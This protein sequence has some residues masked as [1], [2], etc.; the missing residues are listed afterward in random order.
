MQR[1]LGLP[2]DLEAFR[3]WTLRALKKHGL[4]LA[5]TAFLA[6]VAVR[7][8][9]RETGG[10]PAVPLDDSFIHF[11]Y[12]RS[13]WEGRFLGYTPG[14]A[15]A[16]GA[17]SLLWP[18]L[19]ALPYALGL[20]GELLIWAAWL[21]GFAALGLLGYETRRASERLLS[22]DG[23]IAAEL[24]VLTFGGNLWF[25]ASGME[26]IPLA[27]LLLRAARRSAEWA[28]NAAD[29]PGEREL[30]AIAWLGPLLR[31]EGT[32][33][34]LLVTAALLAFPRKRR[35][36]GF[37]ALAGAALPGLLNLWG[38][39]TATTNTAV[40]KWLPLSPYLDRDELWFAF[41][42]NVKLLF[43]TLLNGEVWS[44]VFL[45]EGWGPLFWLAIP[46]LV[47]AGVQR[48]VRFRAGLIACVA[49][50]MLIPATYD[51]FLWNRLRYLWPFSAAWFIGVAAIAD[52]IGHVAERFGSGLERVR[53]LASGVVIGGFVSHLPWSVNDVA[54]SAS[55]INKQQADLGRWA[56]HELPESAVIGVND[57]GAIAY[58]S[59]RRTF[60]VVGLTT[61]GEARYWAAGA[62]S[63]FEHYERLG[64]E[65]LPTH[66]IVYP[67]WFALPALLGEYRTE[68]RVP[69]ATILGGET[70]RAHDAD[71]SALGSGA[72]P[73]RT[74]VAGLRLI[75][76]LDVAD[77]ESEAAHGYELFAATT[78]ENIAVGEDG[79]VDG[80]RG[81]RTRER[82]QLRLAAGGTLVARVSASSP[83]EL[84]FSTDGAPFGSVRV[85]PNGGSELSLPI[86]LNG[87]RDVLIEARGGAVTALHYWS[88]AR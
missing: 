50:G 27:W 61:S 55:A 60:D 49:L 9:L 5:A 46:A 30:V 42:D 38:A 79:V 51:S 68:R 6:F 85:E 28:E 1:V 11:Q 73:R 39:G 87:R 13:F 59:G 17:T 57:T 33:A 15:P 82:F 76:E 86:S 16:A 8:V 2:Y 54:T 78:A 12:A 41:F 25:A 72:R 66:F 75:D 47:A 37:A 7:A 71:Y 14:A 83:V 40:V 63:R 35:V 70:M 62:G 31:P 58:L 53:L 69:G 64:K 34:T 80:G 22:R 32:L 21:F 44:A 81:A 4:R 56:A 18:A 10:T 19:L 74:D 77:L 20:R 65:R 88:Y 67:E 26:V 48:G 52:G 23:A 45:P 24:M 43:G 3:E 29:G 36:L 84:F